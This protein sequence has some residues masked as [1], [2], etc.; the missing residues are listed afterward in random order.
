MLYQSHLACGAQKKFCVTVN[1]HSRVFVVRRS[2]SLFRETP[3]R[4]RRTI[5]ELLQTR[6]EPS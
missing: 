6:R 3:N 1:F 4:E 5:D 2:L